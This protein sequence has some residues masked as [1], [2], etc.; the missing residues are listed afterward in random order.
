MIG[1]AAVV[2]LVDLEMSPFDV[3][4]QVQRTYGVWSSCK[5]RVSFATHTHTRR[6]TVIGP[7]RR[8]AGRRRRA[9]RVRGVVRGRRAAARGA[10]KRWLTWRSMTR[11]GRLHHAT[12]SLSRARLRSR[13]AA[14]AAPP[15]A[16]RSRTCRATST[17]CD[18]ETDP[19]E[20]AVAANGLSF[21][22]SGKREGGGASALRGA[23][24]WGG[25]AAAV[26]VVVVT[27]RR[28]R[29]P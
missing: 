24:L 20:G 19:L 28:V 15:A 27:R 6:N 1:G 4:T 11:I 7:A 22:R 29:D 10:P 17:R 9:R 26:V 25:G 8:R 23:H 5:D 21:L 16:R 13:C 12:H 2:G 3:A 14:A 18:D